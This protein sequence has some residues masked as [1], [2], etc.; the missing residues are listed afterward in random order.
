MI[1]P[2]KALVVKLSSLGDLFHALPAVQQLQRELNCTMDWLTQPEYRELVSTFGPVDRVLTY[3]R[4]RVIRSLPGWVQA[5]RAESYDYVFDFQGLLKSAVLSRMAR[6]TRRVGP[7]YQREG[8]RFFYDEV[9]DS[10]DRTRHAVDQAL[11]IVQHMK[12][13]LAEVTF[14]VAFP[15]FPLKGAR[16]RIGYVPCS[17]WPTK[18]WRN[19]H[20]GTVLSTLN[21]QVGGTAYLL[22][23]AGD[24]PI[25]ERIAKAA[26]HTSIQDFCGRTSLVELG[27][28]ISALDLLITVDSGP[29]HMAAALGVP[30]I[31]LFGPTNPICT[32]PYGANHR[33]IQL[34]GLDC[35]PCLS[36]TCQRP[37]RD[38]ACMD[39]LAPAQVIQAALEQLAGQGH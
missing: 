30:T 25:C 20:F 28:L 6:G 34:S 21:D 9:A 16:P 13:P 15:S 4:R 19:D 3:P 14:D 31:A 1:Q 24:K 23:D 32:G 12:I 8:A 26:P 35:V 37:N 33:I 29:M 10:A 5:L 39:R 7:S 2:T 17:R 27:G 11:D 18:N 36:H 22:G 38:H